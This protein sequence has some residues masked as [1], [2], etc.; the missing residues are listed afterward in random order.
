MLRHFR[1]TVFLS[2]VLLATLN[3]TGSANAAPVAQAASFNNASVSCVIVVD[4]DELSG[5]CEVQVDV[6]GVADLAVTCTGFVFDLQNNT[7][8]LGGRCKIELTTILGT[9][10]VDCAGDTIEFVGPN[11][12]AVQPGGCVATLVIGG[13]TFHVSCLQGPLATINTST[14]AVTLVDPTEYCTLS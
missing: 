4:N 13:A 9:S 7:E 12:I 3:L 5:K 14:L 11:T 2:A 10:E 1:W 8:I 6:P